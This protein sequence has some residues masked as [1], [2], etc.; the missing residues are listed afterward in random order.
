[1][2]VP[3][4][5]GGRGPVEVGIT[6]FYCAIATLLVG[7]RLWHKT[8]APKYANWA[9]IWTMVVWVL[10]IMQLSLL[11][12]S[13]SYGMGMHVD[14]LTENQVWLA[15]KCY[16]AELAITIVCLGIGKASVVAFLLELQGPTHKTMR[17]VLIAVA[18][19]NVSSSD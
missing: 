7:L 6:A 1:M 12:V 15:L 4:S 19:I 10:G 11:G 8:K 16:W 2:A 17:L 9:L 13:V 5:Y 18:I 3:H 14:Q